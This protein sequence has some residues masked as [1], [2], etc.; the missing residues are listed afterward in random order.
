MA[1]RAHALLAVDVV[2]FVLAERRL[3]TRL[4]A[5]RDGPC[6]GHWAFPGSLVGAGESLEEVAARELSVVAGADVHF[7]Q[8][9]TFGEPHRDPRRRVVSTAYLALA[10]SRDAIGVTARYAA[11]EWMDVRTLPPLAYDHDQMA[12]AALDRLRSKLGYTSIVR[13]LLPA[14]FTL[15]ELQSAYETI[16]GRELDRRNFRR[17]I[18]ATGL[19]AKASHRR[20]GPHKPAELFRFRER[21]VV[22]VDIL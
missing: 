14:E 13:T 10:P 6:A 19:L 22:A 3:L 11:S 8:L 21:T 7:E 15:S 4:V 2:V 9:R 18:V 5:V 17:K 20:R 1:V 16:L 12:V